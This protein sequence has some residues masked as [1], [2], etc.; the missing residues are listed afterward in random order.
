MVGPNLQPT[1]EEVVLPHLDSAY[2]LARWLTRNEQDAQ[3]VVQE[4][5][6]RAFRY[7]PSFNG[8]HARGWLLTVVR[9]SCYTWMDATRP[10]KNSVEF[11]EN[12]FPPNGREP[13]PEQ[14][15]LKNDN[16]GLVRKA[17]GTLPPNFREV[18]VLR[19]LE[20]MSYKE[21]A[22]ITG[23]PL[24]TVMSTLS[25]AR[26]RLRQALTALIKANQNPISR[27]DISSDASV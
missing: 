14:A 2:N 9:N 26:L 20:D 7:F 13:D 6:L 8:D 12:L 21:I 23:M 24:G 19:E 10:M 25:R 11:D 1:F 5:C 27:Q 16:A 18:L 3:D 17:L 4:A 15:L 22:T